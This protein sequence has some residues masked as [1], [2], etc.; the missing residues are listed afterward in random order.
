MTTV[1]KDTQLNRLILET[2]K[3]KMKEHASQYAEFRKSFEQEALGIITDAY[4]LFFAAFPEVEEISWVQTS[5]EYNDAGYDGFTIR[6]YNIKLTV[7]TEYQDHY[8]SPT[9]APTGW[10]TRTLKFGLD[11][12]GERIADPDWLE[13][14][15]KEELDYFFEAIQTYHQ[16]FIQ[17]MESEY[18]LS[19]RVRVGRDGISTDYYESEN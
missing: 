9:T 2:S 8:W 15:G 3:E 17:L 14:T 1:D 4:A 10:N 13:F 6:G 19:V 7:G 16:D 18:G 12:K 11:D 5:G